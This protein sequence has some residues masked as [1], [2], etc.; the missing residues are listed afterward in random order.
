M[1]LIVMMGLAVLGIVLNLLDLTAG[2]HFT[3]DPD[4]G[5][6]LSAL[7]VPFCV[8]FYL[9]AHRLGSRTGES[10]LAFLEL[11]LAASRVG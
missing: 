4:V 5:L 7:F 6:V 9:F 1:T 3:K 10:V 2:T 11:T 8:G